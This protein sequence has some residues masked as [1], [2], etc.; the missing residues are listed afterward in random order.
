[1]IS[2]RKGSY[3]LPPPSRSF[4]RQGTTNCRDAP[5]LPC[6]SKCGTP[7]TGEA[8]EV[9]IT[10][11]KSSVNTKLVGFHALVEGF[12]QHL[13]HAKNS[14]ASIGNDIRVREEGNRVGGRR[15][16]IGTVWRCRIEDGWSWNCLIKVHRWKLSRVKTHWWLIRISKLC[17]RYNVHVIR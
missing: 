4:R 3:S 13:Q 6:E 7:S 10:A 2:L 15:W 1:M 12:L 14:K 17:L 11:T 16:R 5:G 8:G 9:W